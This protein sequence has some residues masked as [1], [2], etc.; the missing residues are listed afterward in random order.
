[1]IK[2]SWIISAALPV[3]VF[4]FLIFST[5]LDSLNFSLFFE[6]YKANW[7]VQTFRN[8]QCPDY[9]S[10][11]KLYFKCLIGCVVRII[12]VIPVRVSQEDSFIIGFALHTCRN[13]ENTQ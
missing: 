4:F 2:N 5:K 7:A 8:N 6:L 9:L 12:K 1:M 10:S 3:V 13:S 11:N